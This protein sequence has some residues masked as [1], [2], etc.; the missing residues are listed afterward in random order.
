MAH[1]NYEKLLEAINQIKKQQES[2]KKNITD[3]SGFV[4]ASFEE[5]R[6][7]EETEFNQLSENMNEQLENKIKGLEKKI[8][9]EIENRR[10]LIKNNNGNSIFKSDRNHSY[11]KNYNNR[12]KDNDS[13]SDIIHNVEKDSNEFKKEDNEYSIFDK[14]NDDNKNVYYIEI[15]SSDVEYFINQSDLEEK[16]D[17]TFNITIHN[18]GDKKIPPK[19]YIK[20]ENKNKKLK[21]KQLID[22]LEG[23]DT[24]TIKCNIKILDK[25][26]KETYE[27]NIII[28]NKYNTIKCEPKKF[29]LVIKK[30]N[31]ESDNS[32]SSNNDDEQ[33][34]L[35]DMEFEKIFNALRKTINYKYS[36]NSQKK[37]NEAINKKKEYYKK[38][39][40]EKDETKKQNLFEKLI[41]KISKELSQ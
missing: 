36:K 32:D 23:K 28:Y 11:N 33:I 35:N 25:D 19:T 27:S 40:E 26:I 7:N 39:K 1:Q 12:Y 13:S 15:L 24:K 21:F 2:L 41:N 8:L 9:Q 3:I 18:A 4:Q 30:N 38:Y 37:I 31:D 6:K 5:Q 34:K 29:K 17:I 22:E 20:F 10:K 14:S 16:S